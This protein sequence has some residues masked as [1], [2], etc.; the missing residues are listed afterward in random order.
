MSAQAALIKKYIDIKS[1]FTR[2]DAIISRIESV[3]LLPM[4]VLHVTDRVCDV[5]F[6]QRTLLH[7]KSSFQSNNSCA[8]SLRTYQ[9]KQFEFISAPAAH[10]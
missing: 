10:A 2:I 6:G 7:R 1:I 8:G 5:A 9:S 3:L 4:Q